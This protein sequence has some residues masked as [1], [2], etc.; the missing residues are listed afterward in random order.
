MKRINILTLISLMA[1]PLIDFAQSIENVTILFLIAKQ[2]EKQ[3]LL[4][5]CKV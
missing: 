3:D 1:M 5:I 2:T 4:K